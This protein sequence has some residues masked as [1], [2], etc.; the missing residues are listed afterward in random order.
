[1]DEGRVDPGPGGHVADRRA[2]EAALGEARPGGGEDSAARVAGAR[3]AA[4]RRRPGGAGP[5]GCSGGA[6]SGPRSRHLPADRQRGDRREEHRERGQHEQV[7]LE[8]PDR[9]GRRR[10]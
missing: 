3:P 9:R 6:A 7:E 10:G 2:V 4:R 8:L 5:V 1:M